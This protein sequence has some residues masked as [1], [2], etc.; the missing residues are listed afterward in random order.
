MDKNL[1]IN[2]FKELNL[3]LTE[4]Q[5]EQ[6]AKYSDMLVET[7]KVMNLTSITDETEIVLKHFADSVSLLKEYNIPEDA[8][9]I[10]VGCGAGFPSMPLKFVMPNNH[11]TLVD[12]LNKRINFLESV[13]GE[14]GVEK[15]ELVHSRAEDLGQ[16]LNYR[17]SFDFGVARAVASL[18]VLCEY[19]LP[20]VKVGGKLIALKGRNY[21]N[22]IEESKKAI[23]VLGGKISD[24]KSV[25]IP[26]TDITHYIVFID[27]ICKTPNNYPRKAGKATKSPIK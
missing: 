12:S 9:I 13:V 2:S 8:T 26:N 5:V 18:N 20:F 27:K 21:E 17:E 22:E 24:V 7:N 23:E 25:N 19:L 11:F 3:E 16:D 4:K 1:L 6:F 15:I 10:D 14:L